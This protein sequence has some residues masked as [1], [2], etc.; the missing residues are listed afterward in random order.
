MIDAN[1]AAVGRLYED[2][3]EGFGYLDGDYLLTTY[4]AV[5]KDGVVEIGIAQQE[6]QRPRPARTLH[7]ELLADA[8]VLRAS[9]ID[10][11][12]VM[13]PPC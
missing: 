4:R 6:G 11:E 5:L 12:S 1:G 3:G 7:V 13:L 2:A 10:W 8:G 9:G